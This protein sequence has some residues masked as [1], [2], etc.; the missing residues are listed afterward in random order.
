MKNTKRTVVVIALIALMAIPS[1]FAYFTDTKDVDNTFT[2]GSVKIQ[3]DESEWEATDAGEVVAGDVIDKNPTVTTLTTTPAYVFMK[4]TDADPKLYNYTV[5]AEYWK[6]LTVGSGVYYYN[7][8]VD[9]A[10]E[11]PALFEKVTFSKDLTQEQVEAANF[12]DNKFV[13]NIQ[14]YAVQAENDDFEISEGASYAE[15]WDLVKE[16]QAE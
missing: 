4:V 2:F 16:L 1:M 5:D 8:I 14:A 11:L 12:E 10:K 7:G 15:A 6:E 9:Q 3:L 13:M